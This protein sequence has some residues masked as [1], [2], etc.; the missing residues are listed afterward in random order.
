MTHGAYE[1]GVRAAR[2][3]IAGGSRRV[4]V[5]GAG[6]AGLGAAR[7]LAD[8]GVKVVVLE[9]RDRIGGRA[10]TVEIGDGV[11]ADA[12]A[13]WMQQWHTNPLARLAEHLG[14]ATA[15][16]DFGAPVAVAADG[17]VGDV[18][19]VLDGLRMA[20]LRA[21]AGSS[22]QEVVASHLPTLATADQRLLH[23]ALDADIDC[24]NGGPH[25]RLS[26]D[27]VFAEPGVGH[28]DRWLPGGFVQLLRHLADGVDVRVN[29]PVRRIEWSAGGVWVDGRP[30]DRCICTVPPWLLHRLDLAPGLPPA[31][32]DAIAHLTPGVVEKVL[33]RFGERWWPTVESGFLRWFDS[34][35]TWCEWADLTDGLG[36][37]VVA[38]FTAA[39]AVRRCHHGR[40]DE[41]VAL[42]ATEALWRFSRGRARR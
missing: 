37:P 36:V 16:T 5:V 38:A 4:L 31:H 42:A 8:A 19:A 28:G 17:A 34:P 3:A 25:H 35:A 2:W 14:V 20:A 33:L 41:A 1:E 32:L 12:G 22:L 10:H 24:E 21:P 23:F 7:T 29:S 13:A 30:A 27:W 15:A 18:V 9:A 11:R 6:F 40:S 26:A 39:A